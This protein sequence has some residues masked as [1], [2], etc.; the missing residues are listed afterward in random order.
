M[1][2]ETTATAMLI[3]F[4]CAISWTAGWKLNS[5]LSEHQVRKAVRKLTED[6][7]RVFFRVFLKVRRDLE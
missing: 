4:L 6:E 7:K 5:I 1:I 3:V 2:D